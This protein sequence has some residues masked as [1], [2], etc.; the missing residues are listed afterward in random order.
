[1]RAPRK[2]RL[3][4]LHERAYLI[5]LYIENSGIMDY[6][7]IAGNYNRVESNART[8]WLL[9]YPGV[10]ESLGSAPGRKI[11]DYGCGTGIFSRILNDLGAVVTGVDISPGMIKVARE[12]SPEGISFYCAPSGDLSRFADGSFDDVISN[13]VLCAVPT[14]DA[15][16]KILRE[17]HR[18]L[19]PGG[20][21]VIMNS[22]WEE[23]NGREFV[24]FRLEYNPT[25]TSGC[26]VRAVTK[27][28]PPIVFEDYFRSKK[29]Y[30]E[31]L[32]GT[33]FLCNPPEL[34]FAPPENDGSWMDEVL[35]PPFYLIKAFKKPA[36]S[37]P[38][39]I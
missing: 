30:S 9:G 14:E 27:S 12:N 11:L 13:F 19:A 28:D 25:L 15:V 38:Q 33:G 29:E 1:M 16:R 10:I 22:D 7:N 23:S 6:S 32:A 20:S 2:G 35:F 17:V 4:F 24:S 39:L 37:R 36:Q 18:V 21:Y 26:P 3:L 31:M 8:L 5:Y 34:I